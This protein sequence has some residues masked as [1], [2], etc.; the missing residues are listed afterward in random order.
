MNLHATAFSAILLLSFGISSLNAEVKA[1][2]LSEMYSNPLA[3]GLGDDIEWVKWEDAIEKAL[4]VNKPIFLLIHK[5]WCHACK[6][7]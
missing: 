1:D 4:E 7:N 6:G 5:T 2:K 3:H